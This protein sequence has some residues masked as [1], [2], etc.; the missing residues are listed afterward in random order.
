[1]HLSLLPNP[2]HLEAVNSVLV[3]VARAK[4][5]LKEDGERKKILPI[6][7]HGDAAFAGQGS[8]YEL[9]NMSELDG[10]AVGGTIHII[11]NNQ[12]GFTTNPKEARQVQQKYAFDIRCCWYQEAVQK[13]R[14]L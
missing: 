1:M 3:G 4:Q 6:L 11:L 7:L 13:R 14:V 8:I 9:L 10:Y 2:S 5:T 12:V